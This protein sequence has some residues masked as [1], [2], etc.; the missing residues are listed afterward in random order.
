MHHKSKAMGFSRP[1]ISV[2][3]ILGFIGGI[4]LLVMQT[5]SP[6][7]FVNERHGTAVS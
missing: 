1:T 3:Q 7:S 6:V 4:L 2:M 5:G